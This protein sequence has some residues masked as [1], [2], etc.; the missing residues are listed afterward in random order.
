MLTAW[1]LLFPSLIG[2]AQTRRGKD[3]L[4]A[5]WLG[6]AHPHCSDNSHRHPARS[7]VRTCQIRRLDFA[8][9]LPRAFLH[10]LGWHRRAPRRTDDAL[11]SNGFT[12]WWI[13]PWRSNTRTR[14]LLSRDWMVLPLAAVSSSPPSAPQALPC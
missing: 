9:G 14:G 13:Y 2:R 10:W 8:C 4:Q 11:Q 7:P 1:W 5:F 6:L 12:R 3:A